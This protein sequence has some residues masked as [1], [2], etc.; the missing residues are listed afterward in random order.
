MVYILNLQNIISLNTKKVNNYLLN[1]S[2]EIGDLSN[3]ILF[4]SLFLNI[5]N[6]FPSGKN[7]LPKVLFNTFAAEP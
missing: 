2:T 5:P 1:I 7:S 6:G 3:C 4:L